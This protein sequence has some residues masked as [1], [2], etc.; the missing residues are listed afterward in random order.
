MLKLKIWR[1]EDVRMP[2]MESYAHDWKLYSFCRRHSSYQDPSSLGL[3]YDLDENGDPVVLDRK[4]RRKLDKGLAFWLAYFEHG[5]CWWGRKNG[6]I[7]G[8]VEFQ[9]D[10]N[11][12]AGLLVWEHHWRTMGAKTYEDRAKDAD[13]FLVSYTA[14]ANGEYLGYTIYAEDEDDA[15]DCCGGFLPDDSFFS[16]IAASLAGRPCWL[17][18]DLTN[19]YESDID[20]A[21][22]LWLVHEQDKVKV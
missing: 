16:E 21:I 7:P 11:R 4:I 2:G 6:E 1:D 12:N 22:N 17:D 9:W 14:W 19:V 3:G 18:G 10:G 13:G 5:D 15:E 20:R 8:G